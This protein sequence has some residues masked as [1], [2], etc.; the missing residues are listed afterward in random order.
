METVVYSDG[1]AES[2]LIHRFDVFRG[3]GKLID[4]RITTKDGKRVR[5]HRL[6]LAAKFPLLLE[7]LTS[8]HDELAIRWKR[9]SADIVEAV[10]NYAYTGKLTIST[11]NATRLYLLAHNLGSKRIVSWCVDFLG[12]RWMLMQTTPQYFEMMLES[13]QQKGISEDSKF[14][15]IRDWL[16]AGISEH[17]LEER[18]KAMSH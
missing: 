12:A 5:A 6:V 15:A 11:R 10:V 4:L 18:A 7:T 8:K 14:R 13:K 3:H 2:L 17:D 1:K 16:E 9:F